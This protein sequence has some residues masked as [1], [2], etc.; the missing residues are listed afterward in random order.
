MDLNTSHFYM[1][2]PITGQYDFLKNIFISVVSQKEFIY[3][4]FSFFV[5]FPF[6]RCKG[7]HTQLLS[8][9]FSQFWTGLS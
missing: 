5:F 8:D 4:F 2:C 1:F 3:L 6:G 9:T 7:H